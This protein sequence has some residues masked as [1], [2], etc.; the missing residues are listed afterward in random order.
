M[1]L[2]SVNDA[3]LADPTAPELLKQDSKDF[4]WVVCHAQRF[5]GVDLVE[6]VDMNSW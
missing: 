3:F 2:K 4:L 6:A 5:T 1:L